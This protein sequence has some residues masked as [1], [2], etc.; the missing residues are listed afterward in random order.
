[1][2][3]PRPEISQPYF[4]ERWRIF[5]LSHRFTRGEIFLK[6]DV[7][8]MHTN[9]RSHCKVH[10]IPQISFCARESELKKQ[11]VQLKGN[12]CCFNDGNTKPKSFFSFAR[13]EISLSITFYKEIYQT[14]SQDICNL[15]YYSI[16]ILCKCILLC[17]C[18]TLSRSE[19][20]IFTA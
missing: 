7:L 16:S 15:R 11:K 2:A 8:V 5:S 13:R 14:C 18:A 10:Y 6:L 20:F 3:Q 9:S 12:D 19:I 17:F 4:S 1:M